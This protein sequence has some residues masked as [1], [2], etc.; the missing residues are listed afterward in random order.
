MIRYCKMLA[1]AGSRTFRCVVGLIALACCAPAMA[2]DGEFDCL[3]EPHVEVSA[4]TALEGIIATLEVEKG[5]FVEKGQVVATLESDVEK[6]A[7]EHA[8]ARVELKATLRAR[9][10]RLDY[11]RKKHR[12]AL[13]LQDNKFISPDE[14]D[15][16]ESA[17]TVAEQELKAEEENRRLARLELNRVAAQLS[18]RT[19]RSPIEGVVVQRYLSPGEFAQAQ[20]ILRL[21]QLDPLNCGGG[22]TGSGVR[23]NNRRHGGSNSTG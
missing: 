1:R 9:A 21:A 22:A 17:V 11:N 6:A 18:M 4:S 12:R 15:E 16:F 13:K 8:R 5:D 19:I 14:I 20:P 7:V 3:L 23:A 2:I 10:A